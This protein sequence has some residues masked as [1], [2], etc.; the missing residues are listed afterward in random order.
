[1]RTARTIVLSSLLSVAVASAQ[2][3]PPPPASDAPDPGVRR[4]EVATPK[5]TYHVWTRRVGAS[6]RV[7]LLVLHG[8]PGA[9]H[10]YL[11]PLERL[12]TEG[13][14]EVIFYDQLGGGESDVPDEPELWELPRFVDEV[15]QV[16]RALGLDADDF[17]LFGHSW[18]GILAVEYALAH[19]DALAGLV[20]SNMMSSIPA[21]NEY[22]QKV[23]IPQGDPAMIGE[24]LRLEAA[25][26]Y[27]NPRYMELL[28]PAHYEKHVLRRPFADWPPEVL[29]AFGKLN[30]KIYV[31]MQGPSELGASGKLEKWDRSGD[32]GRIALPT[33]VI[34]A[35]N[36]TMDPAHMEWMSKQLPRG[37]YLFCPE[38]SHLALWDDAEIYFNGLLRFLRESSADQQ[39]A[40]SCRSQSE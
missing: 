15:D 20:I 22:A 24:A 14:F 18:G 13:G 16:R 6:P 19:P 8:G 2:E 10:L 39:L 17:Y 27:T 32:L 31:P 25:G 1:M 11:K 21:Y 4:I 29:E 28:I 37:R 40:A 5:G 12:A 9:S 26:D 36:D 33:L 23:L 34:G 35:G 3:T 38:G 30:Q 7:K